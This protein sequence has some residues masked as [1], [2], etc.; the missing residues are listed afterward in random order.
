MRPS[1]LYFALP[2]LKT[3]SHLALHLHAGLELRYRDALSCA[4]FFGVHLYLA[5]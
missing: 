2:V 4:Q 1:N 3:F 5:T